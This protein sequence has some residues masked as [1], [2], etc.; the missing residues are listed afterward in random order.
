MR[1]TLLLSAFFLIA[2]AVLYA[3]FIKPWYF[4]AIEKYNYVEQLT[5]ELRKTEALQERYDELNL[6]RNQFRGDADR[7]LDEIV[8][9][10]SS[11]NELL[12]FLNLDRLIAS[13]GLAADT[14]Y[15]IGKERTDSDTIVAV[16]VSFSFPAIDYDLFRRFVI[17]LQS[18]KRGVRIVSMQI[19]IA[20]GSDNRN[21]NEVRANI[22]IDALFLRKDD[23]TLP[24][25]EQ[26][27]DV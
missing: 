13:N 17:S 21:T 26:P 15:D 1:N 5:G 27:E 3:V 19:G 23:A 7:L 8:P 20:E 2:S 24:A 22:T 10:Y 6:K 11:E 16:P 25:V 12:F 18:W 9:A 14:Q 4:S